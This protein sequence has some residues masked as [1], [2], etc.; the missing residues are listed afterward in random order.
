MSACTCSGEDHAGPDVTTGR[1]VPEID[2]IEA[3]VL[4]LASYLR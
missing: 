4:F 3:S 1:G 2:I